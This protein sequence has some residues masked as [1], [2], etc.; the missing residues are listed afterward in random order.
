MLKK[1]TCQVL[2]LEEFDTQKLDQFIA[3]IEILNGNKLI[4][5]MHNGEKR[6]V[7][8]DAPKRSDS[9]TGEMKEKAR[10][11]ALKRKTD[12]GGSE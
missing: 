5:N 8:W 12:A 11:N 10:L 9:W 4:F 2:N 3:Q 1:A 7:N 6:E